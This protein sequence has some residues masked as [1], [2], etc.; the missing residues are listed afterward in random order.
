MKLSKRNLNKKTK[1]LLSIAILIVIIGGT[2]LGNLTIYLE[3]KNYKPAENNE[4][5]RVALS[6]SPFSGEAFDKSYNYEAGDLIASNR[7]EL[8]KMYIKSGA[9]EMYARIATKRYPTND[10]IVNGEEDS[11]ANFHTLEQGIE[12]SRLAAKLD[13]PINPEIMLAYTYM[14]MD[15]QQ[16]PNF[17][18][19]PEIY[20]LQNRKSWEELTLEE[21][22]PILETYGKFVGMEILKTGAT[23]ENWNIGNEANFGFAGVSVGLKTEVNNKL[24]KVSS[25]I[26]NILPILGT[27]WLKDN[28]WK[29]NGQQMGAIAK[30]IKAAYK[31]LGIDSSNIKFSTHIATVVATV[32]N[33][34]TYFNTLKENGFP[35]DVAGISFYPSA[36]GVYINKMTMFKKMVTEINKKCNLP[37]FIAEF[38]YPSGEVSGPYA[39]WSKTVKGYEHNEEGQ[40]AIYMDVIEWGKTH[41]LAGIRYWAPDYRGW[42]SMSMFN[43]TNEGATAK[44]ILLKSLDDNRN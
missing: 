17:E 28:V 6:V 9:T 19:Y 15:R 40:S 24:E 26:K 7:E 42:D 8:E 20:A 44:E 27:N 11:N 35:I 37:V 4:D 10:N 3:D 39:G 1:I 23:V 5:F 2:V 38:S 18:E 43:Y 29:Y 32:H 14:D 13:I 36:P 30:G 25:G 16:A 22:I 34:V 33:A 21:M 41:G 31:E 12:L